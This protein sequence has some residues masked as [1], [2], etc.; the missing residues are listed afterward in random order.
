MTST[1]EGIVH[2]QPC[3]CPCVS[4][5]TRKAN[6][7]TVAT[8]AKATPRGTAVGRWAGGDYDEIGSAFGAN[9]QSPPFC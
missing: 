7:C 3:A 1:S 4:A 9:Q 6:A 5:E 2:R 8:A